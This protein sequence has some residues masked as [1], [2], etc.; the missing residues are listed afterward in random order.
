MRTRLTAL[1]PLFVVACGP[2][3]GA[4]RSDS[5]TSSDTAA[6]DLL[7]TGSDTAAEPD[8]SPDLPVDVSD[9]SDT[10]EVTDA[11]D[12]TDAAEVTDEVDAPGD[13]PVDSDALGDA[14]SDADAEGGCEGLE[15]G[16][17]G[18]DGLPPIQYPPSL[19]PLWEHVGTAGTSS[20]PA[21]WDLNSDGVLDLLIGFGEEYEG[22][23]SPA[24]G[25]LSALDGATGEVLWSTAVREEVFTRPQFLPQA[26][27]CSPLIVAGGR[28]GELGAYALDGTQVWSFFDGDGDAAR[29]EG[30]YNFYTPQV[31]GDHDGDGVPDLVVSNGG[32]SLADPGEPRPPGQVAVVSGADG[33]TIAWALTP[34]GA[35]TYSSVALGGTEEEPTVFFG[36]GGETNQGGFWGVPLRDVLAEDLSLAVPL[37]TSSMPKGVIAPTSLADLNLDGV[38]DMVVVAFDGTAFAVDGASRETLWSSAPDVVRESYS[39]PGIG[40]LDVDDVPDA[41]FAFSVGSFPEYTGVHLLAL[42]GATGAELWSLATEGVL[43]NSPLFAD[44]NGDGQEEVLLQ[45]SRMAGRGTE[46]RPLIVGVSDGSVFYGEPLPG[47]AVGT[48]AV[49]DLDGDGRLEWLMNSRIF[50]SGR[51]SWV[52]RLDLSAPVP[53]DA[54]WT[55]Y[56][57][58]LGNARYE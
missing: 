39:A 51:Q 19:E 8:S 26:D 50:F 34:D 41:F 53:D 43:V 33:T 32:N 45:V 55:G 58:R 9:V 7:D 57:G 49:V 1:I 5:D 38:L 16:G 3:E 42:S 46:H 14:E 17:E 52:W 31:T 28:G 24:V 54:R 47:A 6:A 10:T 56:L 4:S 40:H 30:I 13:V 21:F 11:A 25:A 18:P 15:P 48:G 12:V 2:E 37:Y 29:D 35:E 20:S 36:T 27:P 23:E 22:L 44:L